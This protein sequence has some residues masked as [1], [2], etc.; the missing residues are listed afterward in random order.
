MFSI[1]IIK[2]L[3]F[4]WYKLASF[5]VMNSDFHQG[6]INFPEYLHE[7]IFFTIILQYDPTCPSGYFFSSLSKT[8]LF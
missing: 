4:S 8:V 7:R 6:E 3:I 5:K 2:G 1:M